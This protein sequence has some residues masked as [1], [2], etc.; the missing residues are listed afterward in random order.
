MIADDP[1]GAGTQR[2]AFGS[3]KFPAAPVAGSRRAP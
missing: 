2:Q 3:V 1:V